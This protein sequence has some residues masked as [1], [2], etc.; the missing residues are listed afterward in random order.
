MILNNLDHNMAEI[1]ATPVPMVERLTFLPKVFGL[2]LMMKAEALLYHTA[3]QLAAE[4]YKGGYWEYMK[5]SNGCGY[6]APV[7]PARMKVCVWG[8]GFEGEMSSDAAGIVFTLFV[9]NNLMFETSGKD[10]ALTEL[11]I[12]N[13]EQLRDYAATHAE[14][15]QI[16][17]AID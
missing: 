2:K 7:N 3:E 17:R 9:L 5:V 8:N 13:W 6:A 10:E 1:V 4:T 14:A 15:R 16:Y 11:L 12:K